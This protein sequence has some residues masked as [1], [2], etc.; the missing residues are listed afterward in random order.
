MIICGTEKEE[1]G[2]KSR[3]IYFLSKS[4]WEQEF[5]NLKKR[6]KSIMNDIFLKTIYFLFN[7]FLL[8]CINLL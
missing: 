4:E 3:L 2:R 6:P 5:S 7:C 8:N 1:S